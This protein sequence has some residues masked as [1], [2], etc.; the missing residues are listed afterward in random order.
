VTEV[1]KPAELAQA[2]LLLPPTLPT[3]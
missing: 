3:E 1:L 2:K